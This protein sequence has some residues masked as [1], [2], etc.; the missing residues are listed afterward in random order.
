[1]GFV[2]SLTHTTVNA[3]TVGSPISVR[4]RIFRMSF[5]VMSFNQAAELQCVTVENQQSPFY[6]VNR[7]TLTKKNL[8]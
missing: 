7:V 3:I 4:G 6:V 1:M 8:Y 2:D 5:W